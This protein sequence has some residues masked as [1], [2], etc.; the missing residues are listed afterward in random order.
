[1]CLFIGSET[2]LANILENRDEKEGVGI[3]EI[4][5]YCRE[6]GR[7]FDKK[8]IRHRYFD[9]SN[10]SLY[11]AVIAN[12]DVFSLSG[13]KYFRCAHIEI[14]EYNSAYERDIRDVFKYASSNLLEKAM[15]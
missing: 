10:D 13:G 7:S 4:K 2:I 8:K 11:K 1:M 9:I 5:E 12:R 6:L 3:Q 15:V 14:D